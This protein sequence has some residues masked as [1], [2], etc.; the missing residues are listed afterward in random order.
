M[1]VL[2]VVDVFS[3]LLRGSMAIS[4]ES[5]RQCRLQSVG[6]NTVP[7]MLSRTCTMKYRA[8]SYQVTLALPEQSADD[9]QGDPSQM[10]LR[11]SEGPL[12][13]PGLSTPSTVGA[14]AACGIVV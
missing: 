7:R 4:T 2:K 3:E 8:S 1:P 11:S 6:G 13:S 14:F 10:R 9:E 12:Y 5:V